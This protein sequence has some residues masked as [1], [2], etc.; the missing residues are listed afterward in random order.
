MMDIPMNQMQR[1][2]DGKQI[3]LA[4]MGIYHG[5]LWPGMAEQFLYM[6]DVHPFFEQRWAA[7]G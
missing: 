3:L 7:S 4:D 5:G 1:A 2:L 6:A